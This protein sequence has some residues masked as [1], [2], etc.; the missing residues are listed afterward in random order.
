MGPVKT[1]DGNGLINIDGAGYFRMF[2]L[3]PGSHSKVVVATPQQ[4]FEAATQFGRFTRLL[5]D[6]DVD[7]LKTTLPSFHDLS[8]RYQQFVYALVN[9][10][11]KRIAE[12]SELSK[13]LSSFADIVTEYESIKKNNTFKKRVTH[14]DTKISNVLFNDAEKA[15]CVI[16]MDTVMPGW[17]ISDVGDMMRTYVSPVSEE[18]TD[19]TKIDVRD[20]FYHAI[21]DGYY[22]EMKYEMSK[23]EKRYFFYAAEF[24]IYMQAIRF[25]TDYINDDVYY[26]AKYEKQNF[27]RAVN[28]THLLQK[29]IAKKDRL[30][31]L[32]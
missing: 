24:M 9:G 14:H 4:A 28:Q 10:N 20:E 11:K 7:T 21:V 23:T 17:F 22:N 8:L 32:I 1:R 15:I 29:L 12:T 25:L 18:E 16:D 19:L 3:V 27:F 30:S 6:F 5:S 31:K 13:T 26:K 2:P